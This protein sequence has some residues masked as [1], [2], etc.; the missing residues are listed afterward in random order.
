VSAS[1][2]YDFDAIAAADELGDLP[3]SDEL[4]AE[5]EREIAGLRAQLAGKDEEIAAVQR[6]VAA[7]AQKELDQRT[8]KLIESLLP[9]LDNL[10]RAVQH[11]DAAGIQLVRREMLSSLAKL[12]V[13]H[14]PA[15]G[16]RFDPTRHEAVAVVPVSDPAQDG[17]VIDVMREGYMIGDVALRPAAVAVGKRAR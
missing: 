12:G 16:E 7:A 13:T 3:T 10:D 15:R 4:T 8:H 14:A 1:E 11:P 17:K 6:R 9:V 5:L 2:P